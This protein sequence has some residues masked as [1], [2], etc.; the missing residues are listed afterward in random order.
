[1]GFRTYPGNA[2][3]KVGHKADVAVS[4]L[5]CLDAAGNPSF[6]I[7]STLKQIKSFTMLERIAI[8][9]TSTDAD[10]SHIRTLL[11]ELLPNNRRLSILESQLP[12]RCGPTSRLLIQ[13]FRKANRLLRSYDVFA[14]NPQEEQELGFGAVSNES[15][16]SAVC[17]AFGWAGLQL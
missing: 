9:R 6:R 2:K 1:M 4:S 5:R 13:H 7:N 16:D 11:Q 12:F 15:G 8:A 17:N 10:S 3:D 14:E